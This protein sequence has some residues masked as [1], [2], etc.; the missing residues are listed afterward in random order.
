MS[1]LQGLHGKGGQQ[2][3]R[4]GALHRVSQ[5]CIILPAQNQ[6]SPGCPTQGT[7]YKRRAKKYQQQYEKWKERYNTL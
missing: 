7:D 1:A 4:S 3:P 6:R 5:P 2:W